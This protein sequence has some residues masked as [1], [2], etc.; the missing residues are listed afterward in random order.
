VPKTSPKP[1]IHKETRSALP[2]AKE[3][4]NKRMLYNYASTSSGRGVFGQRN[5]SSALA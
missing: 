4:M 1:T 2:K 3:K 5:A